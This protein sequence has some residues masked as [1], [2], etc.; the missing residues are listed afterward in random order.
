MDKQYAVTLYADSD[1][2]SYWNKLEYYFSM[3]HDSIKGALDFIDA[4]MS[5]ADKEK[6]KLLQEYLLDVYVCDDLRSELHKMYDK[7][8]AHRKSQSVRKT[9]K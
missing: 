1:R 8:C 3:Q 6:Y 4:K 5:E 9:K 7:E 2:T